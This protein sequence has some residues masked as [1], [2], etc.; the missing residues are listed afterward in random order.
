MIVI[1]TVDE[2]LSGIRAINPAVKLSVLQD[3]DLPG[4]L[5]MSM[6]YPAA[7]DDPASRDVWLEAEEQDWTVGRAIFF[8]VK[9]DEALRLSVSFLDRNRVAYTAWS[10]LTGGQWQ[11]VEIPF[12]EIE[13]NPYFQPPGADTAAAIDVSEV[14]H[15]GFAPQ[16]PDGGQLLITG[17]VAIE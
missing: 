14:A 4:E 13:P 3:S 8:R 6:E 2:D 16:T 17:F 5:V 9:P 1:R 10:D 12:D 11:S 7:T 15:I